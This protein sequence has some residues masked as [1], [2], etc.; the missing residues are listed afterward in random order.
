M[1]VY[2]VSY[3][4]YSCIH[5]HREFWSMS[6]RMIVVDPVMGPALPKSLMSKFDSSWLF[7]YAICMYIGGAVG[8]VF[9][10]RKLLTISY[11]GL[12]ICMAA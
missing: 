4:A 11:F 7:T 10:L 12:S 8:D 2:I 9:D 3:I 1:T 6:K 5:F